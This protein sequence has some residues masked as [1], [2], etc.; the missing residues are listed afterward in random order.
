MSLTFF[1]IYKP[2]ATLACVISKY[3]RINLISA[4]VKRLGLYGSISQFAKWL[5]DIKD[6]S[7]VAIWEKSDLEQTNM[8]SAMEKSLRIQL[9][10]YINEKNRKK[11]IQTDVVNNVS[12]YVNEKKKSDLRLDSKSFFPIP[13]RI[14]PAKIFAAYAS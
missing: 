4:P 6:A 14:E 9:I 1:I 5:Q 3:L 8:D 10:V 7:T 11:T 12:H 13:K 2:N